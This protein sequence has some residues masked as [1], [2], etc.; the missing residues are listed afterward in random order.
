MSPC[1][2]LVLVLA[3]ASAVVAGLVVYADLTWPYRPPRYDGKEPVALQ[4]DGMHGLKMYLDPRDRVITTKIIA[5]GIWEADQTDL[6][7]RIVKPGDVVVDAGANV[8]YYTL[9]A[10]RLVGDE[11]KVYAFEPEPECF[12]LLQKNVRLNG[13]TNVVLEQKALSNRKG[14]IKLYIAELNQGD[15]RIYQPE[16]ESRPSVEIEAVRLDEYFKGRGR[17]IDVLKMDTQGAEGLILEGL[18]GLLEGQ[19]DGPAIFMEFWPNALQKMGTDSGDL[20]KMLQSYHY[21]IYDFRTNRVIGV[22]TAHPRKLGL[23]RAEPAEVLGMNPVT[24]TQAQTDLLLLRGGR[25]LSS[26]AG[27]RPGAPGRWWRPVP[28]G[29]VA[30]ACCGLVYWRFRRNRRAGSGAE[31]LR[32]AV[33]PR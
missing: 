4:I 19:S 31:R 30:G 27:L 10:S 33:D 17:R 23:A 2:F 15:H 26:L 6:F 13:L 22:F 9:L 7:L 18:T 29:A 14:V 20:L 3:S 21:Q 16:G 11:G 24:S 5:E 1:R 28:L 32:C 8:G 12:A 25:E